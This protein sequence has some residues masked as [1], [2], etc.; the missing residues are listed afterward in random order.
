V[1]GIEDSAWW[2]LDALGLKHP[3]DSTDFDVDL[4]IH[5][6]GHLDSV[7]IVHL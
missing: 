7:G 4:D 6:D 2:P 1:A 3:A 5:Q